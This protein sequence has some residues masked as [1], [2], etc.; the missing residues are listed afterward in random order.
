MIKSISG[1]IML[2]VFINLN[3]TERS[4]YNVLDYGAKPDG[5]TICTASINKAISECNAIGGGQVYFPPGKYLS[6]T[7]VLRDKVLQ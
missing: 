2:V 5:K 4:V 3:A 1:L 6:G 7:I